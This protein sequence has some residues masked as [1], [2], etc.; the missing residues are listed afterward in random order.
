MAGREKIDICVIG[1]GAGGLSVAVGAAGMGASVVLVERARMGGDCL[2]FGCVPSK[3][4]IAA[5]HAAHEARRAGRFGLEGAPVGEIGPGA[6]RD[7]VRGVIGAI[8]PQDSVARMRALGIRVIEGEARFTDERTIAVDGERIRARRFVVA[9]GSGPLVPPI[10]GLDEVP[11]FTNETLFDNAEPVGHLIVVGGGPIGLEMAQAHRRLGARVTVVEMLSILPRDD[12][13]AVELLRDLLDG[14]G[15]AVEEGWRV[16]AVSGRAE[17]IDV[18]LSRDGERRTVAGTHLLIAAGRRPYLDAL[19]LGRA[20]IESNPGGICV[21]WRL[22]TTNKRVY[23]V[24]DAAGGPQF[25]HVAG[26]HAGI[27]LKNI[28]FRLPARADHRLVPRVTFTD[29][30]LAHVG[31]GEAEARAGGREVRVLR[32]PF[33]ENDRAQAE[34]ATDGMVK[35]VTDKRGRILGATLLGPRAGEL[36]QPWILAMENGLKISKMATLMAPYPT[37]GE[38]NKRVAGSFYTPTLFSARTR[39][40]VRLLAA[41]G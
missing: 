24:G 27:V 40:L 19:D 22:R 15:V 1:A 26:Y 32:W 34:R 17:G 25:T 23:A 11:Y 16:M 5:A 30:E 10:P 29:P 4:L 3:A 21:D 31:L 2:N 7:H 12:S 38:V 39:R 8:Q 6:V 20:G 18:E 13:E 36:L 33:A 14:E 28:L 35:V 37:L 9:T 41:F